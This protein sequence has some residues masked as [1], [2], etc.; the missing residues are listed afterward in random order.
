MFQDAFGR[1][2]TQ[3]AVSWA[4]CSATFFVT[5]VFVFE[6]WLEPWLRRFT[7]VLV[8]SRVVW[9]QAGLFFRIWGLRESHDTRSDG[10]VS[11]TGGVFVV[12]AAFFPV[13]ALALAGHYCSADPVIAMATY[14]ASTPLVAIFVFRLL[15]AIPSTPSSVTD[16]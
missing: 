15:G 8:G 5:W 2:T 16:A 6:R 11:L 12:C 9:V 3:L 7:S 10:A 4:V 1:S 13:A 14:L